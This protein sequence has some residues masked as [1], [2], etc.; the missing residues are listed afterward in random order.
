MKFIVF[1]LN[2]F[3]V[4]LNGLMKMKIDE[5]FSSKKATPAQCII[6]PPLMSV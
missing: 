2:C 6:N 3:L 4:D 1:A 5:N